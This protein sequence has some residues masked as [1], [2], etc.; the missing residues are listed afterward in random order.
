MATVIYIDVVAM[1][2]KN[3]FNF[4]CSLSQKSQNIISLLKGSENS[5]VKEVE[6]EPD[7]FENDS[8]ESLNSSK[9]GLVILQEEIYDINIMKGTHVV[10]FG[11]DQYMIQ[12]WIDN[13]KFQ[14]RL[15]S[16]KYN[17][18][19]YK[20]AGSGVKIHFLSCLFKQ[21]QLYIVKFILF[22]SFPRIF[23]LLY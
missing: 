14:V 21:R 11:G 4:V 16:I 9:L 2:N 3:Q 20:I 19:M 10:S 12:L 18:D 7:E 1:I 22:E 15:I 8:R 5:D 6:D 23:F 13:K 17:I